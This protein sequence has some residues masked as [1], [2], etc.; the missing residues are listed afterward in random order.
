MV[1]PIRTPQYRVPDIAEGMGE[2]PKPAAKPAPPRASVAAK[3][4]APVKTASAAPVASCSPDE[5]RLRNYAGRM[6]AELGLGPTDDL[7]LF[8]TDGT[9]LV[10]LTGVM[11]AMSS[12]ELGMLRPSADLIDRA[13]Q[14]AVLRAE[15]MKAPAPKSPEL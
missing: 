13:V 14:R 15:A 8:A 10:N 7:K 4:V 1:I 6:V 12:F 5:Q 3:P 11:T 2:K 9:P